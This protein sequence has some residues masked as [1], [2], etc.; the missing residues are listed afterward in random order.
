MFV[1]VCVV[2]DLRRKPRRA[3]EK[4]SLRARKNQVLVTTLAERRAA[5]TWTRKRTVMV[6]FL[7]KRFLCLVQ[8]CSSLS[9]STSAL[10][11]PPLTRYG[12]ASLRSGTSQT[13]ASS[14]VWTDLICVCRMY[15]A[16]RQLFAIS[17]VALRPWTLIPRQVPTCLIRVQHVLIGNEN[18]SDLEVQCAAEAADQQA[19]YAYGS[20]AG[21]SGFGSTM[22]AWKPLTKT[23]PGL[24]LEVGSVSETA[25]DSRCSTMG[26]T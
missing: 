25:G 23:T 16:M 24:G 7:P 14:F 6:R 8:R 13:Y 12:R 22:R 19:D 15:N 18:P 9:K 2:T 5:R 3:K 17:G 21:P 1:S 4:A 20:T 26:V 11:K 10:G